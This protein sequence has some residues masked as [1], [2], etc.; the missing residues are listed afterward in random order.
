MHVSSTTSATTDMDVDKA[1]GDLEADDAATS[2]ASKSTR[3]AFIL[4][5]EL[6]AD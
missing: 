4:S 6:L 1:P 5:I 2:K 3:L